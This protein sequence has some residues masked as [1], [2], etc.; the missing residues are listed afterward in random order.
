[1]FELSISSSVRTEPEAKSTTR[2]VR[3]V[4]RSTRTKEPVVGVG[5]TLTVLGVVN[6]KV[7]A[8]PST[9]TSISLCSMYP[10]GM[11]KVLPPEA[12]YSI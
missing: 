4:V 7:A 11:L 12:V 3:S 2:F 6:V 8:T 9:Y 5:D 10:N 1:M